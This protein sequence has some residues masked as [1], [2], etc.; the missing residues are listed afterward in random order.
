VLGSTEDAGQQQQRRQRRH[1]QQPRQQQCRRV[2]AVCSYRSALSICTR[3]SR[4]PWG[5]RPCG[6]LLATTK[7]PLSPQ[8]RVRLVCRHRYVPVLSVFPVTASQKS[9]KLPVVARCCL[10][11]LFVAHCRSNVAAA[12]S[13]EG[14]QM[15]EAPCGK[16]LN[17]VLTI[18]RTANY[19]CYQEQRGCSSFSVEEDT[20]S[21]S[22]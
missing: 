19:K 18:V 9:V 16:T 17:T 21:T 3:F 14:R 1:Q 8:I 7:R 20:D 22:L 12:A 10:E 15:A 2:I 4:A 13:R 5:L 6:W 11:L